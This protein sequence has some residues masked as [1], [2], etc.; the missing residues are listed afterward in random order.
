M[1]DKNHRIARKVMSEYLNRKLSMFE[2]VHH[3][4]GNPSNNDIS[5]LQIMTLEEHTSLHH[6]GR[7]YKNKVSTGNQA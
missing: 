6:A 1:S 5:N 4:D 7:R 2:I 3:K